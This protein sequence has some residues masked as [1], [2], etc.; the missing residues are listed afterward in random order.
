MQIGLEAHHLLLVVSDDT[1]MFLH[2]LFKYFDF[3]LEDFDFF[4]IAFSDKL[5]LIVVVAAAEASSMM[6]NTVTAFDA[7]IMVAAAI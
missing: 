7:A 2:L 1:L 3:G 6:R 4:L 5:Y